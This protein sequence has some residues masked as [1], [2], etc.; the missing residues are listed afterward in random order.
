MQAPQERPQPIPLDPAV[1]HGTLDNG[2][3]FYVRTNRKPENRAQLRLVLNAGSIVEDDDQRGLAHFV[4]HMAFNGTENFEK[5]ELIDY[6]ES[7][8]MRFG[9]DI[10]AYT[11]FDETVYMLE[12]P[13]DDEEIVAT[14]F[15]IL[16]D[17]A[18]SVSF[19]DGE[20]DKE[21]GVVVE[22]WRRGRGANGRIRDKLRLGPLTAT[23]LEAPQGAL[24]F[25]PRTRDS[26]LCT[27]T[28][29]DWFVSV[30]ED[31]NLAKRVTN[32]SLQTTVSDFQQQANGESVQFS[33]V[34][35]VRLVP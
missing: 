35:T 8:G 22:E 6:L 11:S 1:R 26:N 4:E 25:I 18:H 31:A 12:I 16:E 7:V 29:H 34:Y 3:T 2:L 27:M 32:N 23:I 30:D 14:A 21:R 5:Q 24:R 19:V 17:W 15:Q 20:I 33:T 28:G 13:T 10:N 9:P